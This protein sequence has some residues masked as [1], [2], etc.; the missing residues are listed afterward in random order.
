MGMRQIQ[1][2]CTGVCGELT[3]HN[4]ATPNHILHLVLSV[5]TGGLWVVPWIAIAASNPFANCVRCGN[6][7]SPSALLALPGVTP[8]IEQRRLDDLDETLRKVKG[9]LRHSRAKHGVGGDVTFRIR[10]DPGGSVIGV[11]IDNGPPNMTPGF[12]NDST[13]IIK[14]MVVFPRTPQGGVMNFTDLAPDD[15]DPY[16]S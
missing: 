12:I 14:G 11:T 9:P 2:Q 8:Q 5:F 3:P 13:T 1:L 7:R 10:Y 6:R 16:R 15:N 4:Q